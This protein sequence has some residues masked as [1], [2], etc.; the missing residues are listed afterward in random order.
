LLINGDSWFDTNLARFFAAS[1]AQD[2]VGSVLL[3][4]M[5]DC[6]RY[7][8]AHIEG[9][10]IVA[11][12]E[13]T[14]DAGPGLISC[15]IYVFD[16]RLLS[17]LSPKCSLETDI[18]PTLVTQ[19]QLTASV[20]DGFFIDIGIPSDYLRAGQDLPRRLF[21]PAIFFDRD[22]MIRKD[23]AWVTETKAAEAKDAV[24][25]ANDAG[26]HA[27]MVRASASRDSNPA[28]DVE[29]PAKLMEDLLLYGAT[30]DD[31]RLIPSGPDQPQPATAM[32][33]D[34][35]KSWNVDPRR[36][37]AIGN[38]DAV[39]AAH[40]A[41]VEGHLFPGGSIMEFAGPLISRLRDAL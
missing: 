18:I 12:R 15:G 33:H 7:G 32:I 25:L 14:G 36:A 3:R 1:A 39:Q 29:S 21:R 11:F 16:Q 41:G 20:L 5:E 37:I 19:R 35:V 8:T 9:K 28:L 40:A 2:V 23:Q 34:I 17:L 30:I 6:A 38:Q 27:F 22:I 31:I 13:K 24:R 4:R 26:V 10:R